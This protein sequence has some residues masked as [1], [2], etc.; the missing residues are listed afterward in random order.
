MAEHT[1]WK[2]AMYCRVANYNAESMEMQRETVTLHAVERGYAKERDDIRVYAD[3]GASG[4]NLDRSGFSEMMES[5]AK[6]ET[7]TVI[8]KSLDRISRDFLITDKWLDKMRESGVAVKTMYGF[9]NKMA[10]PGGDVLRRLIVEE[11]NSRRKRQRKPRSK[12][13]V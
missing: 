4:A 1:K 13:G 2:V 3:N 5:I 9:F 6:G 10:L 8:V 11:N 7:D 12:G